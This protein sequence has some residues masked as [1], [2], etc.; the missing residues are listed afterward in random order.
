VGVNEEGSRAA[1][2]TETVAGAD[3]TVIL[4]PPETV[5]PLGVRLTVCTA[6]VYPLA[7]AVMFAEPVPDSAAKYRNV[8]LGVVLPPA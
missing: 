5:K 4:V 2:P 3:P 7:V 1:K 8:P 6:D